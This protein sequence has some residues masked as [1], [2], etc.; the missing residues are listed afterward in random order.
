M[1]GSNGRGVDV[2]EAAEA[3]RAGVQD[4][5][6]L[7]YD[8]AYETVHEELRAAVEDPIFSPSDGLT[9]LEAGRLS[10]DRVRAV[11][12]RV[13]P[14]IDPLADPARMFALYEWV[15]LLDPTAMSLLS[16]HY[17]LCLG[18]VLEHGRGRA[19]LDDYIDELRA[20]SS[21]GLYMATEVGYGNNIADL[22]TEAVYDEAAEEFVIDT[23]SPRARKYMPNTGVLTVPKLAVV[24]ARLK[25]GGRDHGVFPFIVRV[26]DEDGLRP[27]VRA[28][29]LP[30]KPGLVLDNGITHFDHVR[31]PRRNLLGGDAGD[32]TAA[33]TFVN[34]VGGRRARCQLS[35]SRVHPGR[36]G[37]TAALVAA[38]RAS[39]YI[40][41]RYSWRR[42][43]FAPGKA[44][45]LVMDYRSHQLPVLTALAKVYAMTFL[46]NH[47]K[48]EY[49]AGRET[50]ELV[51]ITKALAGWEVSEV[52]GVCRERCGA[53]GMFSIN[54]IADYVSLAQGVVTAEG[55][56]LV[57]LAAAASELLTRR[58]RG[59]V[60]APPDPTGGDLLDVSFHTALLRYRED[61]LWRT[62]R[63]SMGE[64]IRGSGTVFSAWNHNLN[65]ALAMARTRGARLALEQF[66][67]A[68]ATANETC[69][70]ALRL[71]CALYALVEI[72]RDT[73]WFLAKGVL[74]A[75]QVERLPAAVDHLCELT[76]P[77]SVL[78][79]E[80]FSL[81][82]ELLRAPIAADDYV[83]EMDRLAGWDVPVPR[84]GGVL[85]E[86][87]SSYG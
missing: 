61:T 83:A 85:A 9:A 17:N 3:D 56:N 82:P 55:D 6:E 35:M 78:L 24:M 15:G 74:T 48:R 26:T 41:I 76:R 30:Q 38:G 86:T 53:Q 81:S 7:V 57:I 62:V 28:A 39:V 25:A 27:G 60:V 34:R 44:G 87:V 47:V 4:L 22:E 58:D 72:S 14:A 71:L 68:A 20:M 64:E 10:Y 63:R 79:T 50:R 1:A 12:K 67:A 19:D 43:T 45:A 37:L 32:W 21:V 23:P 73:G 84:C 49:V 16:I 66:A 59:P 77:Y 5:V 8:G 54:R 29:A 70:E 11:T 42:T 52:I 36:L 40:T 31:V 75:E 65:P 18:T 51:S 13:G 69:R 46:V 2:T 80:G 33:G